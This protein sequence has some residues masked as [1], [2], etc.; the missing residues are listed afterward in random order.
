MKSKTI[1][2]IFNLSA[3]AVV[4]FGAA[5]CQDVIDIELRDADRKYVIEGDVILGTDSVVVRVSRTTSFFDETPPE[6]I[7]S[8]TVKITMPNGDIV[9]LNNVGNGYYK[10]NGLAITDNGTY[11]LNVQVENEEFTANTFMPAAL[12]LDS[13][14]SEFTEGIFGEAGYYDVYLNFQ[15]PVGPNYYRVNTTL[16]GERLNEVFDIQLF[17]DR[18]SD[19]AYIRIPNFTQTYELGDTVQIELQS[20]DARLYKFFETFTAIAGEGAGSPFSAA[21]ANPETNIK[22]GAL[23]YFGAFTSSKKE[24]IVVE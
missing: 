20:I 5:G 11:G 14:D 17:D 4:L 12:E 1:K 19:G 15:D 13:L 16:N 22:G 24:I 18:F 8:A 21:P 23:G 9:A 2:K 3:L 6:T 7:N 10:T